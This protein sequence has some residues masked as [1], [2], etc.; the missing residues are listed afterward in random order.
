MPVRDISR[1]AV[2][3]ALEEFD[4]RGLKAMLEKYG[5]R[6]STRWYVEVGTSHYDQKLLVRAAHMHQGLG[7]FE[8]FDAIQAKRR[9]ERLRFSVVARGE[10]AVL[11]CRVAWMAG[12]QSDREIARGGGSYVGGTTVPHESRNF[13]PVGQTYYGI[14]ENRGRQIRIE[15]LGA[16]PHQESIGGITVVFCAMD[17]RARELVVVGWYTS[18]T[19]HRRPIRRPGPDPRHRKVYFTA[20]E[21]TLIEESERWFRIPKAGETTKQEGGGIGP[22]SFIWYGLNDGGASKL[23]ETLYAYMTSG[24]RTNTPKQVAVESRKRQ[25][26]QGLERRGRNRQ[27]IKEKGYRCEACGWTIGEH[28][29]QVW[30]SSFELHHLTPFSELE[31][32]ETREVRSEDFAVLCASC[33]RAIHRTDYVDDVQR[34]AKEYRPSERSHWN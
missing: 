32:G 2:E 1:D 9:L 6:P 31:E 33:H 8:D 19:V 16:E 14:V 5:G 26:S 4:R 3:S 25:A 7:P 23:R 18:A 30:G 15:K 12:Y 11:V 21:A 28:D 20:T 27:F 22:R 34:F 10:G 13:L 17:P 24:A 29:V